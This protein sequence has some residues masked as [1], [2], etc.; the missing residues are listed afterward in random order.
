MID[1]TPVSIRLAGVEDAAAL[2]AFGREQFA[3]TFGPD[4]DADD[5]AAYLDQHFGE[6]VQRDELA[7]PRVRV[8]VAEVQGQW[9]GYTLSSTR[10]AAPTGVLGTLPWQIERFYVDRAWHGQG[11]SDALMDVTLDAIARDDAQVVWLSVWERNTRALRFYARRGFV[12][13]GRTTF[14]LGRDLQ[15]DHVLARPVRDRRGIAT[16]RSTVRRPQLLIRLQRGHDGRDLIACVRADGTSSWLRTSSGLARADRAVIAIGATL[17]LPG[18]VCTQV[19][20]GAEIADFVQ[21]GAAERGDLAG[22]ELRLAALLAAAPGAPDA[23]HEINASALREALGTAPPGAPLL[24]DALL[25]T[26]QGACARLEL[27][28]RG[29]AAGDALEFTVGVGRDGG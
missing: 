16:P 17:A 3:V 11:L 10:V 2:A 23:R 6:Q 18:G 5:L 28:W 19:A 15:T 29:L 14:Q 21:P 12:D 4:N 13:V 9:A 25:L 7:D 27:A 22:W 26:V 1:A 24:D 20:A 8:F